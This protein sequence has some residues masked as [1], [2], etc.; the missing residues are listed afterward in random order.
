[1]NKLKTYRQ[2]DVLIEQIAELPE[3]TRRVKREGG[4]IILARGEA[5]GHH[6]SIFD[7][8]C[9]LLEAP[10]PPPAQ[11]GQPIIEPERFLRIGSHGAAVEHQEHDTI[12]LPAG[13]YRV[14]RQREYSPEAIRN[15]AD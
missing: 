7:R 10:M 9:Q 3:K 12:D 6:H 4:L 14:R 5:T 11:L 2:G 1:M 15:V 8:S 13:N